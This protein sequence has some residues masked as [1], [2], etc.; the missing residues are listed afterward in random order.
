MQS[1]GVKLQT[2]HK[3]SEAIIRRPFARRTDAVVV[4]L[5][6]DHGFPYII[7]TVHVFLRGESTFLRTAIRCTVIQPVFYP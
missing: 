2:L 7:Y 3:E 1:K 6:I 5:R 4:A